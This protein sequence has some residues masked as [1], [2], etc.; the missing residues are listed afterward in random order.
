MV[1]LPCGVTER[2]LRDHRR[3]ED[4]PP[5]EEVERG[6]AGGALGEREHPSCLEVNRV[7]KDQPGVGVDATD[8]DEVPDS[9]PRLLLHPAVDRRSRALGIG[10]EV[11]LLEGAP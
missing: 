7:G 3:G 9:L 11:H 4:L 10:E 6:V 2:S 1:H 8:G 5:V